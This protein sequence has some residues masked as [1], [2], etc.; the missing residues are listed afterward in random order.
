MP[1]TLSTVVLFASLVSTALSAPSQYD[2]SKIDPKKIVNRDVVVIGGGAAGTHAAI[3][4]KDNGKCVMLI[5]IK[6]RIGGHT[7]TVRDPISGRTGEAGVLLYHN[8]DEVKR[9]FGRFNVPLT[10]L[11]LSALSATTSA[12]DFR[13]GQVIPAQ[14]IQQPSQQNVS[15]AFQKYIAFL[16]KYPKLDAGLF[17]DS[18]VPDELLVPMST[19]ITNL[20]LEPIANTLY[21]LVQNV[22]DFLNT[23]VIQATRVLGLSLIKTVTG[24]GFLTSAKG[25]NSELYRNAQA[26]L[27]AADS[28]WLSS[29]VIHTT[30]KNNGVQ[31]VVQT[32]KGVKYISAKKLLMAIPPRVEALK[33]FDLRQNEKD[34]FSKLLATGYYAAFLNNTGLPAGV[35]LSNTSPDQ[36]YGIPQLPAAFTIGASTIPGLSVA[37]FGTSAS[38]STYPFSDDYV[39][40]QFVNTIKKLQTANPQT[41][42]QSNPSFYY[43]TAHTPYSVQAKAEDVKAGI[44]TK[45][46]ALQ[47]QASTFWT[48]AAWRAE[49]SSDI[50]RYNKEI[51]LPALLKSL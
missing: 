10:N 6:D 11:S 44:Y 31:L 4:L 17:V 33:D 13:T 35:T 24:P 37:Y 32:P 34:I 7:E 8:E 28:L 29:K 40:S 39:K 5:D 16:A 41:F 20:G 3:G 45:M 46:Y 12:A 19:L 9:F 30:R 48:G 47:G 25:D 14:A 38:R 42:K 51:V 21:G 15:L 43:Y 18:P 22:G 49:D 1:S 26:E 2:F 50:W 27:L 36:P 23:P